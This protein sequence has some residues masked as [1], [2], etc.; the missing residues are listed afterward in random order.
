MMQLKVKNCSSYRS[1]SVIRSQREP[2]SLPYFLPLRKRTSRVGHLC[3]ANRAVIW[4]SHSV[5]SEAESGPARSLRCR[6][7]KPLMGGASGFISL[8]QAVAGGGQVLLIL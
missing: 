3:S 4:D 7:K 8:L 2:V 5:V 6:L 1:L